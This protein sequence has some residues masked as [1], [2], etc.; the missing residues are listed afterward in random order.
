MNGILWASLGAIVGI[1]APLLF[2]MWQRG[3]TG[4]ADTLPT[5]TAPR[6]AR[7]QASAR[8]QAAAQSTGRHQASAKAPAGLNR[9][10]TRKFH[11]V[12]VKPGPHACQAAQD[13]VGQ[14]FLPDEAPAMPLAAC[15]LTKCQCAYSHHGDRRDREDRRSG[16]GTFGGFTPSIPGGN[17]RAKH[18]DR[19]SDR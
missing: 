15:D 1:L 7:Q 19:R 11:G 4:S 8:A 9:K 5:A 3:A 6:P 12:S 13:L 17:R 14:R 10:Q 2:R 18:P 16:W